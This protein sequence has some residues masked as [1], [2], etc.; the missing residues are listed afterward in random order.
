MQKFKSKYSYYDPKTQKYQTASFTA[1]VEFYDYNLFG[2]LN[3]EIKVEIK[4]ENK[5]PKVSFFYNLIHEDYG[6]LFYR[7]DEK[8]TYEEDDDEEDELENDYCHIIRKINDQL[9]KNKKHIIEEGLG[10]LIKIKDFY[11]IIEQDN[12][13]IDSTIKIGLKELNNSDDND[14]ENNNLRIVQFNLSNDKLNPEKL[15]FNQSNLDEL[16]I[17]KIEDEKNKKKAHDFI[18]KFLANVPPALEQSFKP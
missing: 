18:C 17:G 10:I 12:L 1:E 5:E 8:I 3:A 15:T 4:K 2:F 6:L 16:L 9:E 14:D 11:L 13:N 7:T